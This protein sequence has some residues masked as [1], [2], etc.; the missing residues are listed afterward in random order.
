MGDCVCVGGGG[1]LGC[2]KAI[3]DADAEPVVGETAW[4]DGAKAMVSCYFEQKQSLNPPSYN[5]VVC[6]TGVA[7]H[8]L[9]CIG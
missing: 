5:R 4:P 6:N 8:S 2:P 1:D 9:M 3:Q 7:L